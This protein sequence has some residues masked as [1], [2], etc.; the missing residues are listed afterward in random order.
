MSEIN[1]LCNLSAFIIVC[2]SDTDE[3]TVWPDRPL[4]EQLLARFQNISELE[5]WKKIMIQKTYLKER[6]A[7]MQERIRKILKKN[8]GS[9]Y[10]RLQSQHATWKRRLSLLIN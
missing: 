1:T 6:A 7:K 5:R 4:V 9:R 8:C 2:G 3:P 10:F